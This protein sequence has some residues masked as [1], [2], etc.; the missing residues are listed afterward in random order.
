MCGRYTLS[1]QG[2]VVVDELADIRIELGDFVPR[3]NV[4]PGQEAPVLRIGPGGAEV[5]RLRW[6]LIPSWARDPKIAW[7]CINARAE[8]L[9]TK[10]AFRTAFRRRR[11]AVLADGFYEWLPVPDG[12]QPWYFSRRDRGL[13]LF[14]GLWE[15]WRQS[16]ASEPVDTFTVVTTRPN[17][18]AAPIHDRMPVILEG[19]R[20]QAWLDPGTEGEA[21]ES[22]LQPA[23]DS[24]LEVHLV[25]RVV[26][27]ARFDGPEC[28][29]PLPR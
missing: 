29:A 15:S 24:L 14:A 17:A 8:T 5:A 16:E 9:A 12:K 23:S 6:G 22:V 7:Q 4:A 11:C 1:R 26:N 3:Y 25:S 27:S 19:G 2:S 18:V 20:A 28:I 13:L 21:L 10:P